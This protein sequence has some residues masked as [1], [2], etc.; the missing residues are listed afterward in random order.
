MYDPIGPRQDRIKIHFTHISFDKAVIG[1]RNNK[2]GIKLGAA[3]IIIAASLIAVIVFALSSVRPTWFPIYCIP[4]LFLTPVNL[5]LQN[6][7]VRQ[8]RTQMVARIRVF[9]GIVEPACAFA[10]IAVDQTVL[11]LVYA[12]TLGVAVAITEQRS[13][14]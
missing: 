4:L 1:A 6:V 11:G 13:L 8:A 7:L 2:E 3:A 10:Y 14:A 9:Q 12:H 5:S